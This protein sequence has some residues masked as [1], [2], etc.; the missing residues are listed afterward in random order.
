MLWGRIMVIGGSWV[1]PAIAILLTSCASPSATLSFY[2]DGQ[3]QEVSLEGSL[4]QTNPATLLL[5]DGTVLH[6]GNGQGVDQAL[7]ALSSTTS[8]VAILLILGGVAVLVASYWIPILPRSTSVILIATGASLLAFPVLL[9]RYSLYV[10]LAIGLLVALMIFGGW[11][12]W[13][14][15]ITKPKRS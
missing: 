4:D 9:D 11:D 2:P 10:F 7:D 15:I 14:K 1:L 6:T 13:K 5:P 3:M 12:N 8:W